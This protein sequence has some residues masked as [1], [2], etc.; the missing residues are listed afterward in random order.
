MVTNVQ[1]V[2]ALMIYYDATEL[3]IVQ[4]V[5]TNKCVVSGSLIQSDIVMKTCCL[6]F[7]LFNKIINFSVCFSV[8]C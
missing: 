2:I 8:F 4:M 6:F 3:V 7:F 5:R 1:M